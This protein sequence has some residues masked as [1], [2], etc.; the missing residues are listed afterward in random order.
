M[1][2][3]FAACRSGND[4]V[5]PTATVPTAPETTTTT[6]PYAIPP[7]IDGA[8]VSR[9]VAGLDAITGDVVRLIVSTKTIPRE[10]FDR[11]RAIYVT[12]A[13]VDRELA[14]YSEQLPQGLSGYRPNPGN[15]VT[16]V[17]EVITP[18]QSCVFARVDR[19]FT[20]VGL[21][22]AASVTQWIALRPTDP[23]RDPQ[24]YNLTGWGYQVEGTSEQGT[25]PRN[26][27]V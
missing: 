13:G 1:L 14:L 24:G 9:I 19:D 6:N 4:T 3:L 26:P 27:C 16:K 21:R 11:L 12:D 23:A 15:K 10:A 25:A 22:G 7:V 20:A 8:Y 5:L 2:A 18:G 17:V